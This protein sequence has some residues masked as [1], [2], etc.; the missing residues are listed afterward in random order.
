MC[1]VEQV[2]KYALITT[3]CTTIRCHLYQAFGAEMEMKMY[4]GEDEVS[5]ED[6]LDKN[7]PGGIVIESLSNIR[8]VASLTLEDQRAE[9]YARALA[10]EDP[11]P[12]KS[13]FVKGKWLLR[14]CFCDSHIPIVL[15]SLYLKA[16]PLA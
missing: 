11:H 15:T 4:Y 8:T 12:V 3:Y 13:N 5:D 2:E 14:H 1:C 16:G 6:E 7:S 9:E 10:K